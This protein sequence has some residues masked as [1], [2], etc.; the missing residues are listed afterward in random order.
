LIAHDVLPTLLSATCQVG[1]ERSED[2]PHRGARSIL[3]SFAAELR[4]AQG[5]HISSAA[6]AQGCGFGDYRAAAR[7]NP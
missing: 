2:A 1:L 7:R 4:P 6:K 5:R 3:S